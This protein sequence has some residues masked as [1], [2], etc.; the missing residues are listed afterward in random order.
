M[1]HTNTYKLLAN[2]IR[3][4]ALDAVEKAKS[5]HPG[6]PLGMADIVSV[7]WLDFIQLA[8]KNHAWED[9]DRFILSNGHGSML[10][11]A[12][13]YL[14]GMGITLE[15]IQQ[16]RQQ[17]S[18]TCGH[19]EYELDK[20][21]ETTTG[22]LGQGLANAVGMSMALMGKNSPAKVYCSVGDG[23]LMEGISQEVC[24]LAG[25]WQ[26]KNL[27]VMWDDNAISIDG[28]VKNWF[29]EDVIARFKA[30]GWQVIT[31]ID[32][33]NYE[34]IHRAFQEAQEAEQPVFIQ[35]KTTIGKGLT[36]LEGTSRVHGA[37]AGSEAINQMRA[38]LG[39]AH[40]PFE[41][42]EEMK[43]ITQ[44]MHERWSGNG[45]SSPPSNQNINF[46]AGFW[47][48]VNEASSQSMATRSASK[49]VLDQ[50]AEKLPNLV[51]GS[52]DLTASNLT[53]WQDAETFG[54]NNYQGRYVYYGVREFGMFGIANGLALTGKIAAVGTFMTFMDY[55][56]SAMRMAAM[57][58]LSVV[59]VLTH[60]SIGL[61]EDGPTH[62][63][64]EHLAICRLTPNLTL[65]RPCSLLETAVAWEQSLLGG[66]HVLSLSR[67][68]LPVVQH[69][70]HHKENIK[71]G[72]YVLYETDADPKVVILASGSEA[73]MVF[74]WAQSLEALASIRI[75]SC[76]SLDRLY[77]QTKAYRDQ[78]LGHDTIKVVIEA[79]SA[80]PWYQWVPDAL[81]MTC[82]DFGESA[83]YE[84]IYQSKGITLERLMAH[85]EKQHLE[86]E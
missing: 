46:D 27:V 56:R 72:A 9:R 24:S 51:V 19:P 64:V 84:Q 28:H 14:S 59:Y 71:K 83:P 75:V 80:M 7:L 33:H 26:L 47:S 48:L 52:A 68:K 35:F 65:W 2:G 37:P 66:P 21:I 69:T 31:D 54:P 78:L 53:K 81:M 63:P 86:V 42:P 73:A 16:F 38:S 34:A 76:P 60:D 36:G 82:E 44:I 50:V 18:I 30:M 62:Q 77:Q 15:D 8:P 25:T 29:S 55:G 20:G 67:Q 61:G 11:Y 57:M 13:N 32:G 3:F 79:A 41:I 23:C 5:G 1:K 45:K 49:W 17:G 12:I 6:M 58:N 4:L 22:P 43:Q 40:A 70:H 74:S 85:L 39:W 10:L